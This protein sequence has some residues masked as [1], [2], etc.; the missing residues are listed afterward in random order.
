MNTTLANEFHSF[1][2]CYLKY[3]KFINIQPQ[4]QKKIISFSLYETT[5][6]FSNLRG[7]YKGIYVNYHLA[8]KLYPGWIVRVYMPSNEPDHIIN[9]LAQF[10]DIELILVETNI[11]LRALRFLPHDDEKVSVWL[12]RDLDSILNE[13]EQ[14]AVSDWLTNYP[15][16]ELHI[17]TDNV[18]HQWTITGGMFG[19]CNDVKRKRDSGSSSTLM[20]FILNFSNNVSNNN[21]YAIDCDIAEQFFF[22]GGNY[23]QHYGGGKLLENSKPFPP[24][25]PMDC[26]FV[27]DIV[28]IHAIYSKLNATQD[29]PCL[30]NKKTMT[31]SNNDLFYYPQWNAKCVVNWHSE[32]DFTLTPIQTDKSTTISN[33]CLK[34]VNGNGIKLLTGGDATIPVVWDGQEQKHMHIYDENTLAVIHGIEHHYFTRVHQIKPGAPSASIKMT[35]A[36]YWNQLNCDPISKYVPNDKYIIVNPW[37]AGMSNVRLSFELSCALAYCTNRTLVVPDLCYIDHLPV[38]SSNA[39]NRMYDLRLFFDFDDLGISVMGLTDFCNKENI[40]ISDANESNESFTVYNVNGFDTCHN[41]IDVSNNPNPNLKP[42]LKCF[43]KRTEI[44]LCSDSK[45]L[46]F[47]KCLLGSFYSMLYDSNFD[48][49]NWVKMYVFKHVHYKSEI[50][51][52]AMKIVGWLKREHG[53]YHSMHVRRGDFMHCDYKSTCCSMEDVMKHIEPHAPMQACLYIATDSNDL[54]EFNAIKTKYKVITLRD[55]LN[56][57]IMAINPVFHGIIEQIVCSHGTKFFSHPLSTFSNYVHRLRGYMPNVS[58]KF[59]YQTTSTE[60]M[61]MTIDSNW[62]CASNVWSKEFLDGFMVPE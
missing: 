32:T 51:E 38:S 9:E 15:T 36:L 47:N 10:T 21:N 16:K 24:H 2:S 20:D 52:A 44:K 8:K 37:P 48:N 26:N 5:S 13:R 29:H 58:D 18:Q 19:I 61:L 31:L 11:C 56:E 4:S 23:I 41:Y 33:S 54:S 40:A 35:D 1:K 34:T 60:K 25:S 43:S 6:Q 12:S 50:F 46:Y 7:F 22:K 14:V 30:R 28:D 3:V 42:D 49:A 39:H 59:C 57:D 27:G 55:V 17:M 62:S 53:E 45:Y